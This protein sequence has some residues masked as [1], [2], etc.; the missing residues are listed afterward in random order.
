MMLHMLSGQNIMEGRPDA[1]VTRHAFLFMPRKILPP[2]KGELLPRIMIK[3]TKK[4]SSCA[5]TGSPVTPGSGTHE[6]AAGTTKLKNADG[7]II[8]PTLA[9][10][11]VAAR[12]QNLIDSINVAG[13]LLQ[14][15]PVFS[16]NGT[17]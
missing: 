12:S 15:T 11:L 3:S 4:S 8:L 5:C 7:N 9:Q 13:K 2:G 10:L 6:R 16:V 17:I 14:G 1:M